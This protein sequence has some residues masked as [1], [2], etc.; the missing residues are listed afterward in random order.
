MPVPSRPNVS[1]ILNPST[2]T[3]ETEGTLSAPQSNLASPTSGSELS[4][5]VTDE[6]EEEA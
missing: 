4:T 5:R 3:S 6:E 1:S 2:K